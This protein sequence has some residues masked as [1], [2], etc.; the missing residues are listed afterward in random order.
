MFVGCFRACFSH[1]NFPQSL[2][3]CLGCSHTSEGVWGELSKDCVPLAMAGVAAQC[4]ARSGNENKEWL[5]QCVSPC[6]LSL[7]WRVEIPRDR[8]HYEWG[9][10]GV[11]SPRSPGSGAGV[12]WFSWV[13]A[14]DLF[15]LL[16]TDSLCAFS[17]LLPGPSFC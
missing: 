4:C 16:G 1:L 10:L 12:L 17:P 14:V 2:V 8:S 9:N 3:V 7:A 13:L 11:G 5:P 15:G 6:G